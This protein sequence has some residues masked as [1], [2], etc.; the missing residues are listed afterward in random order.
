M[1]LISRI[2]GFQKLFYYF[3]N[4]LSAEYISYLCEII[5]V[6][7]YINLI[8]DKKYYYIIYENYNLLQKIQTLFYSR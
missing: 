7:N 8:I 1:S 6:I 5:L 2:K 4:Q 3:I